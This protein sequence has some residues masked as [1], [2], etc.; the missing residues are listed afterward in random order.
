MVVRPK[1]HYP[2]YKPPPHFCP[3]LACR[4]GGRNRGILQYYVH[5][6]MQR[7][8]DYAKIL[9]LYRQKFP[10]LQYVHVYVRATLWLYQL[11]A[12]RAE[13]HVMISVLKWKYGSFWVHIYPVYFAMPSSVYKCT[14]EKKLFVASRCAICQC[15]YTCSRSIILGMLHVIPSASAVCVIL[16]C[17]L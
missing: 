8:L 12:I 16:G 10:N 5:L 13:I 7:K 11:V 9:I 1:C 17:S 2:A 6:R 3:M 4:R 14:L 15:T